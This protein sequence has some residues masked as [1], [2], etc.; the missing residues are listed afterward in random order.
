MWGSVGS[1][2]DRRESVGSVGDRRDVFCYF[3]NVERL[4]T[5]AVVNIQHT[6]TRRSNTR[7]SRRTSQNGELS[8]CPQLPQLPPASVL[9]ILHCGWGPPANMQSAQPTIKMTKVSQTGSIS[10]QISNPSKE[11]LRLWEDSNSWGAA[12]WRILRIRNGHVDVLFQNPNQIFTVNIPTTIEIAPE[13]SAERILDVN[14]GNWCGL[15]HCSSY[16]ERGLGG[17]EVRFD[18]DDMIVVIYDVPPT[19]ESQDNGVW[20]GV[21]AAFGTVK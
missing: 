9:A 7:Q 1:V 4:S 14:G 10:L 15:G 13:A 18:A 6:D 12:R 8:V 2:G 20:H 5:L 16:N 19:K 21:A 11:R 3:A 17:K